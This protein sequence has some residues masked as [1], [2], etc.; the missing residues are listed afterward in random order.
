MKC[1]CFSKVGQLKFSIYFLVEVEKFR[2]FSVCTL[3][4]QRRSLQKCHPHVCLVNEDRK[5]IFHVLEKVSG[6]V[7]SNG[8]KCLLVY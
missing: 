6:R 2:L 4:C 1:L 5:I 3:Q 7:F 8:N